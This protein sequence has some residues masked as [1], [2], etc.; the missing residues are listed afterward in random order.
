MQNIFSIHSFR[1]C[2]NSVRKRAVKSNQNLL[3]CCHQ[4]ECTHS[5]RIEQIC[6]NRIECIYSNQMESHVNQIKSILFLLRFD[7]EDIWRKKSFNPWYK[8]FFL[9]HELNQT[10]DFFSSGVSDILVDTFYNYWPISR[11]P[12]FINDCWDGFALNQ[13]GYQI[14]S[15]SN[16]I[17]MFLPRL[18]WKSDRIE[19][20]SI[21]RP[22]CKTVRTNWPLMSRDA[23]D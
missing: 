20:N 17:E 7:L 10:R 14:E 2:I 6:S 5:N 19:I 22:W 13:L 23:A 8:V 21:P 15:I 9:N 3:I 18:N 1:L 11:W 12:K 4:L 16:Q